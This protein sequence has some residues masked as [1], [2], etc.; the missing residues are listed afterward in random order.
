MRT[1][2]IRVVLLGVPILAGIGI[3]V[4]VRALESG[5][6]P[7]V[8]G[9]RTRPMRVVHVQRGPVVPRAIAYGIVRPD[10]TWKAVAQVS[11]RITEKSDEVAV[12]NPVPAGA[13]LLRIDPR[14]YDIAVR[15]LK[16]SLTEAE[17]RIAELDTQQTNIERS[18]EVERES[19]E[20]LDRQYE[21]VREVQAK[22]AANPTEL[23]DS[24]R[25]YL[26]QFARV[27]DLENSLR[28]LPDNQKILEATRQATLTKLESAQLALGYTEVR[29]P[30]NGR[31][32]ADNVELQQFVSVGQ[33]MLA[34]TSIAT[35]EVVAQVALDHLRNLIPHDVN[36]AELVGAGP[37]SDAFR[38]LRMK[39][40]VRLRLGDAPIEWEATVHR[41]GAVLDPRTRT[42][43][44]VVQVADPYGQAEPGVRPP[45]M[46]EM[47][48]EIELRGPAREALA[49]I[50]RTT[51]HGEHVFLV[52]DGRLA[53]Q[54]VAVAFR[55]GDYVVI[56]RGLEDGDVLIVSDPTPAI[57]GTL[58][59][60]S[61]DD[62]LEHRLEQIAA[63]EGSVR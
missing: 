16:A 4:T 52:R 12:G 5:P 45:L 10:R 30:F 63:G 3:L 48:C 50:P 33:E 2:I 26:S 17:A 13:L 35:A 34:V 8:A 61:R 15:E 31:I 7:A 23:D 28:S 29:A 27:R 24:R 22:G 51:L 14:E 62:A 41:F 47:F 53:R 32:T 40:K 57:D 44:V 49:V 43:E 36:R 46:E 37:S 59:A 1:W 25:S 60:P 21:R 19:L 20:I 54:G 18:L 42:L 38:R 39:A 56:E 6:E 9:E 11:G 55:L 58:V